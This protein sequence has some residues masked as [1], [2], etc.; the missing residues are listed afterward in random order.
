MCD[1]LCV[2]V[3]D[4]RVAVNSV[5]K[6]SGYQMQENVYHCILSMRKNSFCLWQCF[7]MTFGLHVSYCSA[8]SCK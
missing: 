4:G 2:Y 1:A 3:C 5:C 8:V 6:Q 7:H